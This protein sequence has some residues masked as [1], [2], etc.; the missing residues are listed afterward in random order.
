M[1]TDDLKIKNAPK[2]EKTEQPV[3]KIIKTGLV[4]ESKQDEKQ[5][6]EQSN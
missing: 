6:P 4:N 5:I 3:K 2:E 1:V